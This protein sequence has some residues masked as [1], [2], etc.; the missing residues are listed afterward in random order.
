M[1]LSVEFTR[2]R[3]SFIYMELADGQTE[4][5]RQRDWESTPPPPPRSFCAIERLGAREKWTTSFQAS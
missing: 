1:C 2:A 5:E 3:R 4:R